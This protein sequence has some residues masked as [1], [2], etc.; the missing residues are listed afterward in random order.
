MHSKNESFSIKSEF[1]IIDNFILTHIENGKIRQI[2]RFDNSATTSKAMMIYEIS[3]Y[4]YCENK[5]RE[6]K[7][8]NIYYVVDLTRMCLYQK[9]HDPECIGYRGYDIPINV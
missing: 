5:K 1:P 2:K 4:R 3:N 8:N 7:S 9:C 6:H